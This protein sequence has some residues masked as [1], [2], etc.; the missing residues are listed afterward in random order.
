MQ[1]VDTIK[2]KNIEKDVKKIADNIDISDSNS[3]IYFGLEA[4]E[5]LNS[6]SNKM[7]EGVKNKDLGLASKSLS[8]M[9]ATIRGFDS[10]ELDPN[11]ELG[12]FEKLFGK[13]KPLVVFMQKYEETK[14]QIDTIA[15]SLERHKLALLKDIEALDRLYDANLEYLNAIEVHIK[16]A[17]L[18]IE[19]LENSVIPKLKDEANNSDDLLKAQELRDIVSA[20]ED[21]DKRVHDLRLSKQV[22]LQALPSIRIIQ[23]NNK[24]LVNKINTTIANTV[25]LWKNQLAQAV[26]IY[27]TQ[28][29]SDTLKDA[30]DLTNEL[31]EQNAKNLKE[32]NKKTLE[33]AQRGVFDIESVKIANKTLIETINEGLKITQQG[34]EA[35]DKATEELQKLESEL[36]TALIE[37]KR[38]KDE[39]INKALS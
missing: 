9:V 16:A 26:A 3:I 10:D 23:E 4:Q 18:K 17:T 14:E 31:L 34:K 1:E 7:L 20:K 11:K 19:E 8:D 6:V 15:N 21:L 2:D 37:A 36:K 24:T 38:K 39:E 13:A 5:K 22:A 35:R 29:A 30:M 27:R 32:S 33:L 25:P 12:F 28:K